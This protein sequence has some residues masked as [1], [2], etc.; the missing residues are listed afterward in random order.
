MSTIH[1]Q[2]ESKS[3]DNPSIL[4]EGSL[5]TGSYKEFFYVKG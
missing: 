5:F 1:S 4:D 2:L 3:K